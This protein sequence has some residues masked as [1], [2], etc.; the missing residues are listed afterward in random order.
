MFTLTPFEPR[1]HSLEQSNEGSWLNSQ[2]PTPPFFAPSLNSASWTDR[3]GA[4]SFLN[5]GEAPEYQPHSVHHYDAASMTSGI[6]TFS[7]A[8]TTSVEPTVTFTS[9]TQSATPHLQHTPAIDELQP[10]EPDTQRN[11]PRKKGRISQYPR[12]TAAEW[13]KHRTMLKELYIGQDLSLEKTMKTMSTRY[14]FSP[15]LVPLNVFDLTGR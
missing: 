5:H 8:F 14:G 1:Q 9:I 2:R 7:G 13:D 4:Q 6:A 3:S 15:S 11:Q 12:Y 10:L